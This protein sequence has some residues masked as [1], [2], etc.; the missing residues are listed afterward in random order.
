ML[1][2]RILADAIVV[3]HACYV[4]FIVLG[5]AAILAG[6]CLGW[7]WV[8]N[9]RFRLVHLA[10]IGIVVGEALAGIPCPL[11]IWENQLRRQAGQAGYPGDF[12]GYWAHRLI[13]YRAEPWV[14]TVLYVTFG[15]AVLAAFILAPPRWPGR[16]PEPA[17]A[18]PPP[19]T[20]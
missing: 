9:L 18:G 3:F 17:A 2:A 8:R 13:F 1:W 7:G 5:L 15:L 14:F 16:H 4:A 12:L 11:T 10:M 6:I 19:S 20:P